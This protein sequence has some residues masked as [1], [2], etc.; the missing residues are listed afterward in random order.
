M[1][2][3]TVGIIAILVIALLEFID[4]LLV[5]CMYMSLVHIRKLSISTP[6]GFMK[7]KNINCKHSTCTDYNYILSSELVY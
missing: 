1:G 7:S 4:I 2:Y 6:P 3:G 5:L